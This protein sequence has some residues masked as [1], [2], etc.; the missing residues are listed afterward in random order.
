MPLF[1]PWKH[2]C[3]QFLSLSH[4]QHLPSGF[5]LYG[6]DKK[7]SHI[8]KN[9]CCASFSSSSIKD[10]EWRRSFQGHFSCYAEKWILGI[11]SACSV[12]ST[13]H[14]LMA[15]R[16]YLSEINRISYSAL[17]VFTLTNPRL[18]R[19]ASVGTFCVQMKYVKFIVEVLDITLK[20]KTSHCFSVWSLPSHRWIPWA[21]ALQCGLFKEHLTEKC[22]SELQTWHWDCWIVG[23][24]MIT[25]H[26]AISSVHFSLCW[27]KHKIFKNL[28]KDLQKVGDS[29]TVQFAK[30]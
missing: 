19:F 26:S 30:H 6:V 5:L 10:L 1:K 27:P 12:I 15:S 23:S 29:L 25:F 18:H 17:L 28:Q 4:H 9:S 2:C 16:T 11:L 24:L 8:F 20:L 21:S 22:S 14:W 13:I 3:R 7:K